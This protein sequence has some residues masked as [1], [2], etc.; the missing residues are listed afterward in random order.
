MKVGDL[1]KLKSPTRRDC[2]NKAFVVTEI[3]APSAGSVATWGDEWSLWIKLAAPEGS[4]LT[5]WTSASDYEVISE[6]R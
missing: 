5:G 1:V 3:R 6:S 2:A 4:Y